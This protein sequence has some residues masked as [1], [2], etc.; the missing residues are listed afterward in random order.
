MRNISRRQVRWGIWHLIQNNAADATDPSKPNPD[1]YM[2]VPLNP[3]S[4]YPDGYYK[5]YGD[6]RHPSYEV[7]AGGRMLRIHY[8]YHMC[9]AAADVSAGWYAVV[10]G[11]KNIGLVESFKY[12]RTRNIRMERRWNSGMTASE[13]FHEGPLTKPWRTTR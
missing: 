1:L 4:K 6:A 10:N 9:K 5:P 2:Y 12:F 13:L 11:Q 7:I 3:H 8:L